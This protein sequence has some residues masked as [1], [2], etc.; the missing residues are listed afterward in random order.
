MPASGPAGATSTLLYSQFVP[1]ATANELIQKVT[2][3]R[4]R[5]VTVSAQS[6][7]MAVRGNDHAGLDVVKNKFY[8]VDLLPWL[9]ALT[10]CLS[11][12]DMDDTSVKM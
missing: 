8:S 11:D 10:K 5:A 2:S 1:L 4:D 9:E 7:E 3:L 12:A 6:V